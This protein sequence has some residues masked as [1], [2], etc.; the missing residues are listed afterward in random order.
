QSPYI[1]SYHIGTPAGTPREVVDNSYDYCLIVNFKDK[2]AHDNYQEE[3]A[4]QV[5]RDETA[6]LWSKLQIYDTQ[7]L[8]K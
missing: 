6:G 7:L 2:E 3:D 5:L 1:I 8:V 4:H